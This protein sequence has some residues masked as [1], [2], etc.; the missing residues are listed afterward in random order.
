MKMVVDI[1]FAA[2]GCDNVLEKEEMIFL[3]GYD[4]ID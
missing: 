3:F 1:I 2:K 4:A